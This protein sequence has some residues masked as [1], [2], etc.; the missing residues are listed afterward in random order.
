[1]IAGRGKG[2]STMIRHILDKMNALTANRPAT[3]YSETTIV[4]CPYELKRKFFLW[5]MPGLGGNS[6]I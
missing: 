2:K 6:L 1:M 3:G 5:D 4:Q